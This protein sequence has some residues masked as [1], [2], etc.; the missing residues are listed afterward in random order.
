[1][2]IFRSLTCPSSSKMYFLP[3]LFTLDFIFRFCPLYH[4]TH[5]YVN[6]G[7]RSAKWLL[8]F[9][10]DL[11]PS[12]FFDCSSS[13]CSVPRS[14]ESIVASILF[15]KLELEPLFKIRLWMPFD[16]EDTQVRTYS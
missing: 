13:C 10:K 14:R 1:M 4:W 8:F 6:F 12:T 11:F 7:Y 15:V 5:V 9:F 3:V 2:I 16:P